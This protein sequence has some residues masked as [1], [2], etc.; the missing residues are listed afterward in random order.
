MKKNALV[1]VVSVSILVGLAL[2]A[3]GLASV[4]VGQIAD[5]D[6]LPC[7]DPNT[8]HA[9]STLG[10]GQPNPYEIPS[11]GVI[12]EWQTR[13]G[14]GGGSLALQT[15]SQD[16]ASVGTFSVLAESAVETPAAE[17]VNTF[18]TRIPVQAGQLLGLRVVLG[19]PDCTRAAQLG[20]DEYQVTPAPDPGSGP[21]AYPNGAGDEGLNVAATLEP[22]ADGDGF[23][24]ETQDG[25][26]RREHRHD[27]CVKPRVRLGDAPSRETRKTKAKFSFSS[28][29]PKATFRCR[30]DGRKPKPCTSPLKVREL[31]PGRHSF[32]VRAMDANDNKSKKA[33]YRWKVEAGG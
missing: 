27:D 25:C 12:T 2:P 13:A 22:D 31:S 24:D 3:P 6:G 26:P 19:G 14:Y 33:E 23:G 4:Q 16:T 17:T 21:V 7:S 20:V 30:I 11:S 29:D 1:S 8:A 15:L 28:N 32:S 5:G 9:A 10:S 18:Q